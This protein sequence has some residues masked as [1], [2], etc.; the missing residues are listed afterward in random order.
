[1]SEP[2]I[3]LLSS[4]GLGY[5]EIGDCNWKLRTFVERDTYGDYDYRGGYLHSALDLITL[6]QVNAMNR[7]MLARS[8]IAAWERFLGRPMEELGAIRA[9]LDLCDSP[10]EEVRAGNQALQQLVRRLISGTWNSR[11]GSDVCIA[12]A[13]T[14]IRLPLFSVRT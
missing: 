10:E 12:F 7:A 2:I 5:R 8:P 13:P 4:D 1:M 9:D 3:V 14:T 11:S 6:D